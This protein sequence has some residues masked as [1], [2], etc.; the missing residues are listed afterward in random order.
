MRSRQD[1]ERDLVAARSRLVQAQAGSQANR[2]VYL[3]ACATA[4]ADVQHLE[5]ELAALPP[6]GNLPPVAQQP[7]PFNWRW[8]WV[9][10]ILWF[11]FAS[12][13]ALRQWSGSAGN[14]T[15]PVSGQPTPTPF[16]EVQEEEE[17]EPTFTSYPD[18]V[19]Y[20]VRERGQFKEGRCDHLQ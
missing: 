12:A 17:E 8:L 20:W 5:A 14:T 6:V 10:V 15:P 11:L 19:S 3:A 16:H 2:T 1:I 13:L 18:C 9:P 7:A 4:E